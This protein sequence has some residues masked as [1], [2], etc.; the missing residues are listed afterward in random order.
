MF[1]PDVD[2][3]YELL[4]TLVDLILRLLL[5]GG[6]FEILIGGESLTVIRLNVDVAELL[7]RLD[8]L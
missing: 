6:H 4:A 3:G 8:T 2:G 5:A 1:S 7:K